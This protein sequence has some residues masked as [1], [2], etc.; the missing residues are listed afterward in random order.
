[1]ICYFNPV[2]KYHDIFWTYIDYKW[3]YEEELEMI[4][5]NDFPLRPVKKERTYRYYK[6][7]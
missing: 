7:E 1:M 5:K 2:E 3:E 4:I 6:K